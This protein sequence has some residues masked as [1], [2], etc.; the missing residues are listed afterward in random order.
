MTAIEHYGMDVNDDEISPFESLDMLHRRSR[1]QEHFEELSAPE[2]ELLQRYDEVLIEN[3]EKMHK[4]VSKVYDFKHDRP[5]AHWWWHLDKIARKQLF[6]SI[7]DSE[8]IMNEF[9]I[10]RT[11]VF[12]DKDVFELFLGWAKGK[13]IRI[14]EKGQEEKLHR[15]A[16]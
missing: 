10:S 2:K 13:D 8:V 1:I 6:V 11:V 15:K 7:T 14:E 9:P 4:H 3:A 12:E 16:K 5:M